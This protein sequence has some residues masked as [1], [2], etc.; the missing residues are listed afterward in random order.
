M[1]TAKEKIAK[2]FKKIGI[3]ALS[4]ILIGVLG[5]P[6]TVYATV[7]QTTAQEQPADSEN[8]AASA[9]ITKENAEE[10][11]L[12]A[13][14]GAS[15]V[16]T[17]LENENGTLVYSVDI[18]TA[19]GNL[20][21]VGVDATSGEIIATDTNPEDDGSDAEEADDTADEQDGEEEADDDAALAAKA[22]L[23]ETEANK[24]ALAA[25]PDATVL[26]TKLEDENG[27]VIYEVKI[28]TADG[29]TT[30]VKVDATNGT[31]L[32]ADNENED[33]SEGND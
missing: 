6:L 14:P 26:S 24:I 10:I 27:V 8:S 17:E 33:M 13:N 22:A 21:E 2:L 18:T 28:K 5:I 3:P 15:V 30:E 9:G 25:Y 11:A 1:K 7:N 32:P 20:I 29:T 16:K 19:N 23:T 31:A 4:L 12:A